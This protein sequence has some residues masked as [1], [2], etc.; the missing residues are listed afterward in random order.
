ME[1]RY[2][3]LSEAADALGISERTT[4]RWIK[5]GRLF[6]FKPGRDYRIPE[7]A[8]KDAIEGGEVN[9]KAEASQLRF[10]DLEELR[11]EFRE[12]TEKFYSAY[13]ALGKA[14][15]GRWRGK[16]DEWDRESDPDSESALS[17]FAAV[18]FMQSTMDM[19]STLK[20]YESIAEEVGVPDRAHLIE[21]LSEMRQV[22]DESKAKARVAAETLR[23]N[24]ECRKMLREDPELSELAREFGPA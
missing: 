7:K 5:A 10:E 4:Y 19:V 9:P 21:A 24:R 3:S 17:A 20:L 12:T 6:A 11:R 16:V 18:L 15:A 22:A 23:T 13:E 8:I 2:L 1:E 14:L